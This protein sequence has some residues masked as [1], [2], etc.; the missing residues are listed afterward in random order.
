MISAESSSSVAGLKT[1]IAREA[2]SEYCIVV[3]VNELICGL[4]LLSDAASLWES[5]LSDGDELMAVRGARLLVGEFGEKGSDEVSLGCTYEPVH[6]TFS[7]TH[8]TMYLELV[9]SA[10]G[11]EISRSTEIVQYTIG[12]VRHGS[13]QCV[14]SL[15]LSCVS[16]TGGP[17][18]G[19]LYIS[20][21]DSAK[22]RLVIPDL[23]VD[24]LD[25]IYLKKRYKEM[26][27]LRLRLLGNLKD[28][29]GD[30][31]RYNVFYTERY[32]ELSNSRFWCAD[33]LEENVQRCVELAWTLPF[34]YFPSPLD[35]YHHIGSCVE[36]GRKYRWITRAPWAHCTAMRCRRKY[37]DHREDYEDEDVEEH[38]VHEE[39][40]PQPACHRQAKH[41]ARVTHGKRWKQERGKELTREEV[42][43]RNRRRGNSDRTRTLARKAFI[44]QS[45][46]L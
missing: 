29:C 20:N 7:E 9:L 39:E 14:V 22:R 30:E 15:D 41:H 45:A 17:F 46:L 1:Q 5:G 8:P 34:S 28:Q 13:E 11:C 40:F 43:I 44:R 33:G 19:T 37:Q 12:E 23:D 26:R 3:I 10:Y 36:L 42:T 2:V 24:V 32:N 31:E 38:G 27:Q 21:H 4:R 25:A 35:L 6:V 16:C 18:Q